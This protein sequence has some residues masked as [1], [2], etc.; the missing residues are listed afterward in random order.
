MRLYSV[1][2]RN[3]RS[4]QN[5]IGGFDN[6]RKIFHMVDIELQIVPMVN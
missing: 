6:N 5:L 2:A 1:K 4:L 3:G